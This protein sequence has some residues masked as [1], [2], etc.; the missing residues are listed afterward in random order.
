MICLAEHRPDARHLEHEP[1]HD[2]ILFLQIL[3][4]EFAGF[5]YEINKYRA[6][7]E[8]REVA[9]NEYG[10]LMIRIHREEFR[11]HLCSFLNIDRNDLILEAEFL[12]HDGNLI[13]VGR[14]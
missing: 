14:L 9:V 3:R 2:R 13:T 8:Y 6:A 5:F 10:D 7:L 12:E 11:R 4:L 1:F